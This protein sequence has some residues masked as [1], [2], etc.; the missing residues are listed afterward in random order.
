MYPVWYRDKRKFVLKNIS[1]FLER[2]TAKVLYYK[3][4]R[5]LQTKLNKIDQ[6]FHDEKSYTLIEIGIWS[7][8][9]D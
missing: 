9:K 1:K 3:S 6:R 5:K 7:L 2:I 4:I 8:P